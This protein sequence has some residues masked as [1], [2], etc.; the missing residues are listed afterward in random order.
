MLELEKVREEIDKIDKKIVTL[1]EERM[2]CS[3][4]VAD[5]K[6]KNNKE[7]VDR[8]REEEKLAVLST[9]GSNEFNRQSI[10]ELFI[11]IMSMSRKLQYGFLSDNF[12]NMNFQC[13]DK[14]PISKKTKVVCFGAEGSHSEQAMEEYFGKEIKAQNAKT[15]REVMQ[16]V[17]DREVDFGIVPI[18]NSST[19]GITDIYDLLI[20]FDNFIVG[21]HFLTINQSL[22]G[23]PGT[24]IEDLTTVY[25]HSQGL[26]QCSKFFENHPEIKAVE[27]QSTAAAAQKIAIEQNIA[28]GAIASKKAA[29]CYNL[30]ILIDRLNDE[31]SNATRFIIIS[32]EPIYLNSANKVSICFELPHASG[33]LYNMLSHIIYNNLNMTKIESRP[34]SGKNW[35]YRFFIDF[36]GNLKD[37]GVKNALYGI[38]QEAS[39]FRVLGNFLNK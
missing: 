8:Q 33:T 35:E 36:E 5:Y 29:K 6:I 19:G 11:Q 37:A 15:F 14:L 25:S 23:I 22:L 32:N 31:L 28:Y 24:K 26:L 9:M 12:N 17:K 21:E 27:F 20:E 3:K 2:E 13:L 10:Q 4:Q 16:L 7:I 39:S 1:L 30:D 18:E 38:Q 34:I